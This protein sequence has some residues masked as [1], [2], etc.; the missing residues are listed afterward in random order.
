MPVKFNKGTPPVARKAI[1]EFLAIPDLDDALRDAVERLASHPA[2]SGL[3][4]AVSRGPTGIEDVI[5]AAAIIAYEKACSLRPPLPRSRHRLPEYLK[6]HKLVPTTYAGIATLARHLQDKL[7]EI[8]SGAR[9]DWAAAWPGDPAMTFDKLL[10]AVA[11]IGACCDRLDIDARAL[12]AA[13]KLPKPPRRR[14]AVKAQR[15]YFGRIVSDLLQRFYGR[16]VD[17]VATILEDVMFDLGGEIEE[18]TARSR[19]RGQ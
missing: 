1:R 3:W 16:P 12:E 13:L 17:R 10:K 15:T 19:R 2:M 14:G 7:E 18:T 11:S 4:A 6:Q 9:A 5:I 8:P